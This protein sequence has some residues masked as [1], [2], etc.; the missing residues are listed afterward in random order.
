MT[1]ITESI[2]LA[3]PVCTVTHELDPYHYQQR[4][5]PVCGTPLVLAGGRRDG[6]TFVWWFWT[7]RCACCDTVFR[8]GDVRAYLTDTIRGPSCGRPLSAPA[9]SEAALPPDK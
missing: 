9:A 7:V 2:V 4:P 1:T 6:A 8:P 5:Y 3:C